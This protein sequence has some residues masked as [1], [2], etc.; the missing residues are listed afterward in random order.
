MSRVLSDLPAECV[1]A[2]CI[3]GEARGE[4]IEGQIAVGCVVR[5][6]AERS[7]HD[8][9]AVCLA[10]KQFSCFN[11]TDPNY[12]KIQRAA[13]LLVEHTP[14]PIL[15]QALW[16][17]TGVIHHDVMDNTHGAQNYLTTGLLQSERAPSWAVN[18]PILAT[19][20]AHS[21]LTA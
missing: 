19:I 12:P 6:R 16:I 7:G 9:W 4:P 11:E 8:W 1:L 5:N 14:T 10:P 2:L 3:W 17:A 13:D 20:G 15:A 21:F 18:R